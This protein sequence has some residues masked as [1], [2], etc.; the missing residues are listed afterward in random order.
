[1]R[2]TTG[3]EGTA[4]M[5]LECSRLCPGQRATGK[6]SSS[7]DATEESGVGHQGIEVRLSPRRDTN[8]AKRDAAPG[9]DLLANDLDL[10]G[11]PD[12]AADR[13]DLEDVAQAEDLR[14]CDPGEEALGADLDGVD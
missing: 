2:T 14:I 6:E 12:R 7:G 13:L 4:R 9:G 10:A 5:R 11:D 8:D 3:I 1:A